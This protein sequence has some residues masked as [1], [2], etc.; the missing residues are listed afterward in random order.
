M[1]RKFKLVYKNN[2]EPLMKVESNSYPSAVKFFLRIKDLGI[3]GFK[4]VFNVK[5][6]KP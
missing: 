3:A 1:A 5:E 2:D 4:K 6:I